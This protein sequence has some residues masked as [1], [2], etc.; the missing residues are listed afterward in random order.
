MG[1]L[2]AAVIVTGTL[3][4]SWP[5]HLAVWALTAFLFAECL[6]AVLRWTGCY[7]VVT[8]DRILVI[9]GLFSRQVS[10]V[11]ISSITDMKF[12]R[13]SHGS[14]LGYGRLIIQSGQGRFIIDYLPYP[15]QLYLELIALAF[16]AEKIPCPQCDG[17]GVLIQ[18]NEDGKKSTYL[19]PLCK[20]RRVASA[21]TL[22]AEN[23]DVGDD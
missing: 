3:R 15:E 14:M 1:G 2:L 7:T 16:P 22:V 11:P 4:S 5:V 6:V 17:Q 8:S 13:S 12:D 23:R 20:G 10:M 21:D 18:L 19:C 9:S